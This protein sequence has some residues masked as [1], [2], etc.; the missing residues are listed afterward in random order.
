MN[1]TIIVGRLTADPELRTTPNGIAT[2]RVTVA[3]NRMPNANGERQA[4][5]IPVVIWRRQAEN[6]SKYCSKGSL[7]GIDG[8]IQT[9]SYD[10]QDGSRRYVTEVVADNVQFLGG[11]SNNASQE[12]FASSTN[13]PQSTSANVTSTPS[14]VQASSTNTASSDDVPFPTGEPANT[15]PTTD[16]GEDPFQDFGSE[17]VLSDNDLPF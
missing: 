5:F 14:E 10:A 3:V 7:V 4:D 1:R 12:T 16:V 2:T 17:V 9:R 8:R 11:R 13:E 15:A 6:V